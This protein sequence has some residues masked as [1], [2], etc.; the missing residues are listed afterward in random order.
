MPDRELSRLTTRRQRLQ[1]VRD[2]LVAEGVAGSAPSLAWRDDAAKALPQL[3]DLRDRDPIDPA[4]ALAVF[5]LL[6]E[7][8]IRLDKLAWETWRDLAPKEKL[9]DR[10]A[11]RS[12]LARFISGDEDVSREQLEQNLARLRRML[13]SMIHGIKN[14]PPEWA[15]RHLEEFGV[16]AIESVVDIEG[17]KFLDSRDVKCWQKY[18]QLAEELEPRMIAQDILH[19]V[20]DFASRILD[21]ARA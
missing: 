13:A 20:G 3:L 8:A 6:L 1:N 9:K 18:K 2:R 11:L 10:G 15:H 7:C 14:A 12:N 17:V 4:R 19:L 16:G 5:D 21:T